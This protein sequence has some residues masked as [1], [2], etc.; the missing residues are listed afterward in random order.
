MDLMQLFGPVPS[1]ELLLEL[2]RAPS[3]QV[4][5]RAAAMLGLNPS[6]KSEERLEEMLS[7]N[8]AR[9]HRAAC[10]SILR[11]GRMP[12][13]L[14]NVLPL[15]GE[16]N[17]TLAFLARRVLERMPVEMFRSE[18]VNATDT[19]IAII[20]MLALVNADPTEATALQVLQRA[21]EMMTGF[22]SDADFTDVLRLCQVALHRG[23]VE[24]ER[25]TPWV[26]KS[27]KNFRPANDG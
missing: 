9:V 11:C 13:N 3:E 27:P 23:K 1:E 24:P 12:K 19:R 22:L 15:L 14:H 6:E 8:D 4:R 7:D 26:S 2:S 20:G 10:E 18:V 21:S 16:E 5:G 25:C 17:R